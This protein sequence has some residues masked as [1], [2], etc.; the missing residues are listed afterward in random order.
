M[1][2]EHN[3]KTIAYIILGIVVVIALG[4]YIYI[5]LS[6]ATP[7]PQPAPSFSQAE[8]AAQETAQQRALLLPFTPTGQT[9][10]GIKSQRALLKKFE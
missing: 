6:N 7:A 2:P 10:A 8:I 3:H 4:V 9:A 5:A 1:N